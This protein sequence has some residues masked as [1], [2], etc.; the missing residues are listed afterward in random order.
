[1]PRFPCGPVIL[2]K[3]HSPI[4]AQPIVSSYWM[5]LKLVSYQRR[6]GQILSLENRMGEG[7][8][9]GGREMSPWGQLAGAFAFVFLPGTLFLWFFLWL[10]AQLSPSQKS[11]PGHSA[12]PG[13]PLAVL[14]SRFVSSS[15]LL[16]AEIATS[17]ASLAMASFPVGALAPWGQALMA[18]SPLHRHLA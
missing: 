9:K 15:F 1:M 14:S 2:R 8:E 5:L 16:P 7:P 4:S 3:C 18:Y 6:L 11:P 17:L 12:H 10:S 13:Y